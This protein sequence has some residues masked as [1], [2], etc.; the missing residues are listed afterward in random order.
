MA[1][2]EA[3]GAREIL[4]SRGNPTVEVEVLLDDGSFARAAV[5]SGASTGAFEAVE[6]R[7]GGDRYL[8]KGVQKAVDA[9]IQTLGPAVEG[10]DADDQRLVDQVMLDAD[11]TPNKAQ[12]GAN[13]ILGVSLAVARAAADSAAL[14]LY[15]YVGG[16]N[17][18][19]LPV[20]MMNI[21]NGGAHADSNVDVQEFMIAPIG[22]PTFKEA[23]RSGAEVYHALKSV[24]K[25]KGLS[26]GLGD[27]GGFAPNLDSNRAALDLIAE[28]VEASGQQLGVDI[29]LAMDVAASEFYEAGSYVFEGAPK[30]TAEMVAYYADLVAAYPI[31]SIEDPLN[32]DDW[33]GWK[34]MTDELGGKIQLVGDDLFVTNVERL[35]RGIDGGQANAMLVKVNQ[36]GSLTE[37]LDAV[38]LAHRAGFRNMMSHRSGE[39]EDTTIADLAVATN[40]G[41][42][43]TGAPARSDRVAKFN[44]LLRI[45]DELGDAARYAGARAFPR[46]NR[47]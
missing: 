34:A 45:E 3:V 19:L 28:A 43:K 10:L 44:Q 2:I 42:I 17:A 11:G 35:Q 37:T 40:C 29:A 12:L 22:A 25:K 13:A 39:T 33:D 23:L 18:H 6:L 47:T 4:D 5:P 26:T 14:P 38:E 21:V 20:P 36:I 41:Q 31:V 9:V 46:F 7:D 15:R 16:P 32:E 30:T 24:L 1:S 8:G 27:E